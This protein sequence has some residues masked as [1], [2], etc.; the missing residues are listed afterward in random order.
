MPRRVYPASFK[1]EAVELVRSGQSISTVAA[2]LG[3]PDGTLWHWTIRIPREQPSGVTTAPAGAMASEVI[4]PVVHRAAL[5]RIAERERENE[6]LGKA[7]ADFAQKVHPE[8]R[9]T[10][11]SRSIDRPPP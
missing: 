3:I 5:R 2:K 8:Q 9:S 11:S 1:H 7:S 6:F 4:D 10:D